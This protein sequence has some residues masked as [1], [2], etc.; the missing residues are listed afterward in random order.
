MASTD[1]QANFLFLK[2]N[3]LVKNRNESVWIIA[4]PITSNART[5]IKD[6]L[7]N[8]DNIVSGSNRLF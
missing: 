8:P 3:K 6:G 4:C 2:T 7:A 1:N 5:A